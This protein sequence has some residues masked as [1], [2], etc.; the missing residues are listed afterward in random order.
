MPVLAVPPIKRTF[1]A[2]WVA[3]SSALLRAVG[4]HPPTGTI[5]RA[6]LRLGAASVILMSHPN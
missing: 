2:R 3:G 1:S 5:R 6:L 4:V